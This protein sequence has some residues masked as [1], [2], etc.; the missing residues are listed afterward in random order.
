MRRINRFVLVVLVVFG[1]YQSACAGLSQRVVYHYTA[2]YLAFFKGDFKNASKHMWAVFPLVKSRDFFNELS[3]VLIYRGDYY[4]AARV[5]RRAIS[6]YKN[7]KEFYYKLFDV[8]TILRDK[9]KAEELMAVI[10]KRFENQPRTLKG[11]AFMYIKNG[12]Y[13]K[14]YPKLREYLKLKPN[15]PA[16]LY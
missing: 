3:D 10:Q 11:M 1:F 14:A 15:D 5:L 16:A 4:K 13:K 7:D 6:I 8:Y 2:G 12:E 9:K